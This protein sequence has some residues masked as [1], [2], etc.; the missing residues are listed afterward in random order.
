MDISARTRRQLLVCRSLQIICISH[1]LYI[2]GYRTLD[3]SFV[4]CY[5]AFL[6]VTNYS[7]TS[8]QLYIRVT[9]YIW[10]PDSRYMVRRLLQA[11]SISHQLYI[12]ESRTVYMSHKVYM[13]RLQ[14]A[15]RHRFSV[16]KYICMSH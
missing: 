2:Y 12:Y 16:T 5:K 8:H 4:D 15:A 1:Q 6:S 9:D 13:H 7:Y 14:I 10:V 11:I 3:T